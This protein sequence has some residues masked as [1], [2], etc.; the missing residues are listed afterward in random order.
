MWLALLEA[1]FSLEL[2]FLEPMYYLFDG[3]FEVLF[4]QL[5]VDNTLGDTQGLS[6]RAFIW[7]P[8]PRCFGWAGALVSLLPMRFARFEGYFHEG[9]L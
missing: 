8:F 3:L 9:A 6:Q 2:H 4:S 7:L 5:W 1:G